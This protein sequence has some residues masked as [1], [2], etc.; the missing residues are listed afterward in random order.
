MVD[1]LT[2]VEIDAPRETVARYA[3]D[4]SNATAWF[5]HVV[6]VEGPAPLPLQRGSTFTFVARVPPGIKRRFP[7]EVVEL[8]D[9]ERMVFRIDEGPFPMET[10]YSWQSRDGGTIMRLH[11]KATPRGPA[12]L[13]APL[14]AAGMRRANRADMHRLKQILESR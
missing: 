3:A 11:N 13:A 14:M 2:E 10:T 5:K 6:E 4:P 9:G 1:V 8:V 12:R 7:Y